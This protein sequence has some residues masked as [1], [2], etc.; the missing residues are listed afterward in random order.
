MYL[1]HFEQLMDF[2]LETHSQRAPLSSPMPAHALCYLS[3]LQS[4]ESNQKTRTF[5]CEI[6][7]QDLD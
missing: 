4:G 1:E 3:I 6:V 2:D 5:E 7:M